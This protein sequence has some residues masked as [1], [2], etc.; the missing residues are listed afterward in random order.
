MAALGTASFALAA[1]T[2]TLG[3]PDHVHED[4]TV[5]THNEHQEFEA[6]QGTATTA[7]KA[8]STQAGVDHEHGEAVAITTAELEEAAKLV[9][10]TKAAAKRFENVQVAMDDGFYLLVGGRSGLAHYLN[11]RYNSDGRI[12]DPERPESLMYLRM[13]DGTWK[14]VGVMYLMPNASQPGPRIGGPLTAWHSHDNLCS[15]N[16]R[17]V[18]ITVNGKCTAGTFMGKT[19][20]MMHVWLVDNPNGVFSDEMEPAA[21]REL[22]ESQ[23]SR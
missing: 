22:V 3:G 13:T 5:H 17:I 6:N 20:E 14:L 7:N 12:V 2:G 18:G 16:G 23:A 19:A 8:S 4:G 1:S 11:P 15:A 10:D 21:L 9:A